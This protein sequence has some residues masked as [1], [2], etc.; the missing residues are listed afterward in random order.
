MA[1]V[2]E[3]FEDS[4]LAELP[5]AEALRFSYGSGVFNAGSVPDAFQDETKG[6]SPNSLWYFEPQ[7]RLFICVD[8]T[9]N[10]AIWQELMMLEKFDTNGDGVVDRATSVT[11]TCRNNTGGTLP[12]G[13]IVY[14]T[15]AIGNHPTIARA[16]NETEAASSKTL[17]ML[18]VELGANADGPVAVNGVVEKLDTSAYSAGTP[19]W[20][21]TNGGWTATKP[22]PPAHAVFVGWVTASNNSNG[23]IALHIQNGYELDELHDVLITATPTDG[24]VLTYEASTALWKPKTPTGGSG[25]NS[26]T[27]IAVSGQ[28]TIVADSATDTLTIAAGSNITITTNATTDTLT[29]NATGTGG[30]GGDLDFGTFGAPAGFTLDLGAF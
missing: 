24:Q 5:E 6:F 1:F 23:R 8:D 21:G 29:I 13:S 11:I 18:T 12:K 16:S 19:L 20:L 15:G 4:D 25:G 22:T 27:N 9:A 10:A 28:D 17:G 30:G 3:D 26:F 2:E 14:V 7:G